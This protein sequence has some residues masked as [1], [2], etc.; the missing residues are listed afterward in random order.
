MRKWIVT[1]LGTGA[2]PIAPGT[3]GSAAVAA[4]FF[5]VAWGSGGR[6]VCVSGT[7]LALAALA[8][9][10]CLALGRFAERHFARKDPPQCTIDEWA[11]Q[12][13]AYLLLPLGNGPGHWLIVAAGG[14]VAFRV[15][16]IIKVSP[17]QRAQRLPGGTGILVDDLV[18][19]VYANMVCQL[20]FRVWVGW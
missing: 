2:L 5:L 14:F 10:A 18:A 8:S 9:G 19:G 1:G 20:V 3:W 12:A 15:F 7:M 4:I 13:L 17:A 16:D 6:W 11:G